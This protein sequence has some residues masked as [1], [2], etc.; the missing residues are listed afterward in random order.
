[1]VVVLLVMV[2]LLLLLLVMMIYGILTNFERTA[3]VRSLFFINLH[4]YRKC[5]HTEEKNFIFLAEDHCSY[6][7]HV[8]VVTI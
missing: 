5:W 1:V 8:S 2:L 4:Q 3:T 7:C 6:L